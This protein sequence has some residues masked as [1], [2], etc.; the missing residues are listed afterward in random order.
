MART[1]LNAG[2]VPADVDSGGGGSATYSAENKEGSTIS[3]GMVVAVHSSGTG[4]VKGNATD[5]SKN[6]V[7]LMVLD[8]ANTI[9]GDVQ[10]DGPFTLADWTSVIGSTSLAAHTLYFLSTTGGLLTA[11]PPST[12]GNVV[13]A[14]GRAV[15]ATTLDIDIQ[16][17]ILL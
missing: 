5:N 14:I 3:A 17:A 13:Q 16:Q 4:V 6:A 1:K 15:S 7:G 11:T 10:T 9:S 2:Q 12:G 8:T